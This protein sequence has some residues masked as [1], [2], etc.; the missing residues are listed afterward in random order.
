MSTLTPRLG[1]SKPEDGDPSWGDE[2]RGAFDTLD[3]HPGVRVVASVAD[4]AAPWDGQ[5]VFET[6]TQRHVRRV[7]GDWVPL[8]A[9]S[10]RHVQGTSASVWTVVHNLG[11]YPAGIQVRDSGGDYHDGRVEYPD[12]N[13]VIISFFVSGV[14][15]AFSGE[16]FLS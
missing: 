10:H 16:A 9:T 12:I 15:A 8:H 13:T 2:V 3:A 7:A 6:V 11:Y 5:M 14:P 1:L 4:I